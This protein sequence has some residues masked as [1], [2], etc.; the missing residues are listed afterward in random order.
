MADGGELL[1]RPEQPDLGRCVS[2]D[3]FDFVY[4]AAKMWAPKEKD[5][6]PMRAFHRFFALSSST[7]ELAKA[8]Q[9]AI[10]ASAGKATE[11]L[12]L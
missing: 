3:I 10:Q 7:V 2:K 1:E 5:T 11:S 9:T 12:G 6:D 4:C 8:R